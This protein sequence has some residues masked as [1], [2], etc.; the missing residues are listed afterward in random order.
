MNRATFLW[1]LAICGACSTHS[2]GL[3]VAVY[4]SGV[5]RSARA[6]VSDAGESIHVIRGY[7]SM[8][9]LEIVR[10][11]Q[12]VARWHWPSLIGE[13]HAHTTSSPTKIGSP[14]VEDVLSYNQFT[15]GTLAPPP[16]RYCS[17][18]G[19]FGPADLDAT[20]LPRDF[21]MVGKTFKLEVTMGALQ[22]EL[23]IEGAQRI[24]FE[25]GA[26]IDVSGATPHASV[27]VGKDASAWFRGID[28]AGSPETYAATF[29]SNLAS[30]ARVAV[31]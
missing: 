7:I 1:V 31:E 5:D 12:P 16:A 9:D 30:S 29:A 17:V 25:V 19:H 28:F 4:S 22:R 21:S 27:I 15:V 2:E 13:A 6:W 14:V 11:E 3:S 8:S 20:N 10:C 23:T 26:T 24:P 18:K